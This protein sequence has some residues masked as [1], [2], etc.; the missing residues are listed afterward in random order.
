[1]KNIILTIEMI[2]ASNF[3]NNVRSTVTK[4]QWD[5]IRK[6][7]YLTANNICEICGDIG[8]NQG[9]KHNLESHEIWSYNT[10]TKIQKLERLIALCPNCHLCKHIGRA[11]AI[12]KQSIVFTHL[13]KINNWNHKEVVTYLVECFKKHKENSKIEWKL[14]LTYLS[15]KYGINKLVASKGSKKKSKISYWKKTKKGGK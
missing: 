11:F 12:G 8:K 13:E 4:S 3:Y 2:P 9:Y 15:E 6:E 14:N 5:K 7:S 10:K 1:M